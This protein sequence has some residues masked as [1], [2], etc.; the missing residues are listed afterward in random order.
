MFNTEHGKWALQWF[1]KILPYCDPSTLNSGDDEA[2][3]AMASGVAV[4]AP[5]IWGN[6]A[7]TNEKVTKFYNVM[8]TDIPP[9]GASGSYRPYMGGVCWV[10]PSASKNVK[11]A[12]EY[13]KYVSSRDAAKI[14]VENTGQPCRNSTLNNPDL[15]KISPY[16][17]ALA[18]GVSQA[19]TP[20][21]IPE[22]YQILDM[23]GTEVSLVLTEGKKI[24]QALANMDAKM[25]QILTEAGYFK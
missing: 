24:E 8:G 13:L 25:K 2:I 15:I 16:F 22:A 1:K 21:I 17:P 23:V 6:P 14:F 12:V 5:F 3:N 19:V 9:A 18:K 11:L 20:P 4:Y 10:V 7:L